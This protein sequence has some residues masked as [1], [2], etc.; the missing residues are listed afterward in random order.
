MR[1]LRLIAGIS[2]AMQWEKGWHNEKILR[3]LKV[4]HVVEFVDRQQAR[5]YGHL[6]RMNEKSPAR[7]A[8]SY[9]PEGKRPVGRPKARL[10]D[11]VRASIG[12][13]GGKRF[14]VG[15]DS[16]AWQRLAANRVAWR[17]MVEKV[18]V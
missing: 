17:K 11:Q 16:A 9:V 10:R 5:W 7:V 18:V 6:F 13:A 1:P 12:R 2:R 15:N 14:D 3:R 8:F 4:Q